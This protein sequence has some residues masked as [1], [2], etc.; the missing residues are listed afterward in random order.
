MS[1]DCNEC[2][3]TS[4]TILN[5]IFSLCSSSKVIEETSKFWRNHHRWCKH[6]IVDIALRKHSREHVSEYSLRYS[7]HNTRVSMSYVSDIFLPTWVKFRTAPYYCKTNLFSWWKCIFLS[8]FSLSK[9]WMH[10]V[11]W[12]CAEI[13]LPPDSSTTQINQLYCYYSLFD[14]FA[15]RSDKCVSNMIA[16]FIM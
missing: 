15:K 6:Q 12:G 13:L 11:V 14:K 10:N 2:N 3:E 5:N 9:N 7:L 1:A 8:M 16:F 4:F